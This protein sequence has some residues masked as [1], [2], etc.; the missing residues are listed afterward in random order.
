MGNAPGT[1]STTLAWHL[2]SEDLRSEIL[3][4]NDCRVFL[5]VYDLNEDWV[6][7]NRLF[8][9]NLKIGGAFHT[10][11]EVHGQ[12]WSYGQEGVSSVQPRAHEVHIYRQSI[13][14]GLTGKSPAEVLELIERKV[15]PYWDGGEY[16]L[17][18]RNCCSFADFL[19]RR[20]VDKRIPAWVNRFPK[21]ASAA[22]RSLGKVVDFGGS[23]SNA[24]SNEHDFVS[25]SL[26]SDTH[27]GQ[28]SRSLSVVSVLSQAS[29]TTISTSPSSSECGSPRSSPHGP[30]RS[31]PEDED[32]RPFHAR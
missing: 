18:H 20:L 3:T 32:F 22:H 30:S 7:A 27:D 10:G 1:C 31:D 19:C 23:V 25:R 28:L 9:D 15:M 21:V 13:D 16:D 17:L 29:M 26:S 4:P 5:N 2:K 8:R 12:E 11:V 24:A 6:R 14:M